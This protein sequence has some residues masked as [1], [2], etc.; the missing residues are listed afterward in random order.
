M[1]LK[2]SIK[3]SG[4]LIFRQSKP[5]NQHWISPAALI[6]L[7]AFGIITVYQLFAPAA[8]TAQMDQDQ[9]EDTIRDPSRPWRLEADEINYD[10]NLDEYT[11]KGNVLIYKG[12][13]KLV[14]DLV[15]FNN[16]TMKAYAEG[17]VI[18][19]NGEDILSG[20]SMEM[21]LEKQ[22][23]SVENGYLFLKENN[24]HLTGNP[25]KKV[26]EKTYTID[27]ATL[28]TCDGENPDWRITGKK[29]QN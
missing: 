13:I 15:S 10:Q 2:T 26:G 9:I 27:N 23:G 5:D 6:A 20:T 3:K 19:T 14:A 25:I 28:T 4:S 21:D 7:T 1:V 24:F 8:L 22:I 16:K 18:F 12:N 17:N 29:D 11:A